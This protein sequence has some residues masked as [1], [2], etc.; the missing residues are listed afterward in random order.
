MKIKILLVNMVLLLC[1][2]MFEAVAQEIGIN[3][4]NTDYVGVYSVTLNG[5][6]DTPISDHIMGFNLVYPQESD[7][8][9]QDG[10][11]EQYLKDV[12]TSVLRWPGGTVS[13]YYHWNNLTGRKP[14]WRDNWDPNV[15]VPVQPS[16]EYMGIDEYLDLITSTGAT[17]LMGINMDSGRRFNRMQDGIDEALA[18]M[19]YVKD[20]GYDVKYWYLGNEPYLDDSNGG[21]K[22]PQ[23][24]ADLINIYA[25]VMRQ[26]DPD[27][28]VVANWRQAFDSR[29]ADYWT[30]LSTAGHNIDLID[31]HWYWSHGG[32]TMDIWLNHTPMR[33]HT[34]ITYINE[35]SVF[36]DRMQLWSTH[37]DYDFTHIQLAA[38]EWNTG[39]ISDGQLSP[40]QVAMMQSE[41]MM[42]FLIGGLDMATFW[43]LQWQNIPNNP[44]SFIDR[45]N[46]NN[47]HPVYNLF[48]FLG[49]FQGG[50]LTTNQ[51]TQSMN[52]V[53]NLVAVDK[54][55][56]VLRVAFLNKNPDN[57]RVNLNADQFGSARLQ[58]AQAYTLNGSDHEITSIELLEQTE[59]EVSF[60]ANSLSIT[61]LTFEDITITSIGEDDIV[62]FF[63]PI[64]F[65]LSQNYP[66]PFNPTTVINYQLPVNSDVRLDVY[67]MVGRKVATL[68]N[69]QQS[70]GSHQV[71]FDATG[72]ASGMY[73]YRLQAGEFVQTR[74]L[75][76]IK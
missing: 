3:L 51:V 63:Q 24:Y 64:E 38:L 15:T 33:L 7:A 73:V 17:P 61:M 65:E 8:V 6:S 10:K 54:D 53:L 45:Y 13:T 47:A 46:N 44:R 28:K 41:L 59:D 26:V 76:L 75:I 37:D 11:V 35:I 60:V 42:Q 34:G 36:K 71:T 66:N 5:V 72:L 16:S 9:W 57:V 22:S 23:Q 55:E 49:E 48:K 50:T 20:K 21:V 29:W 40:S 4:Q 39:G 30:I 12:N 62:D 74:K 18:L 31:V 69:S 43:P 70:A 27:I 68:V 56:E 2:Y 14:P 67:N 25:D 32:P 58:S 1:F 19:H 52:H